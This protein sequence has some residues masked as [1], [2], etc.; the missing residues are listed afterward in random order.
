MALATAV[1]TYTNPMV[2]QILKRRT[3]T[4]PTSLEATATTA[5]PKT[6]MMESLLIVGLWRVTTSPPVNVTRT[7]DGC[8]LGINL[9]GLAAVGR[10]L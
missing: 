7:D 8:S 10:Q 5:P 2:F 3:S 1:E 9:W 4:Q 6:P